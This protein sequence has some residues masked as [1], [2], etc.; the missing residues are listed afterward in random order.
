MAAIDPDEFAREGVSV[1][2]LTWNGG[3][4]LQRLVDAVL[5]QQTNRRVE[6]IAVDR[7]ST[8]GTRQM[9]ESHGVDVVDVPQEKFDWGL[10]RNLSFERAQLPIIVTLSQD[11]VPEHPGWLESLVTPLADPHVGVVCG[12]SKPDPDRAFRQFA[13][14]RNG[15][16]YFTQEIRS[17]IAKYG[18]GVS[19]SN[20]ALRR[21]TWKHVGLGEQPLGEDFLFQMLLRANGF[22]VAFAPE[23]AVLHHHTYDMST[24]FARCRNEGLALRK[25]GMR[26]TV[27]QC[28]SDLVS[29]PKYVQ[30]AREFLRGGLRTPAEF[31]FPVVRP[32]AVLSGSQFARKHRWP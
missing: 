9:L 27:G 22:D 23:A 5:A 10:T 2:L 20:A 1:T 4:L 31:V 15:Y 30:W 6:I 13:W 18:R 17:F 8:D 12:P 14:E 16:F 24:L 11:A 21:S 7:G 26:Y 32:L 19:F 28:M 29:T 25:L 3:A